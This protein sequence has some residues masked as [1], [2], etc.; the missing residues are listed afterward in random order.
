[1]WLY[2][3]IGEDQFIL[4]ISGVKER[5]LFKISAM[6]LVFNMLVSLIG[7]TY[8]YA[9]IFHSMSFPVF[10]AIFSTL[11]VYNIYK[12]CLISIITSSSKKTLGY[13]FSFLFRI[14]FIGFIGLL[15]A[16]GCLIAIYDMAIVSIDFKEASIIELVS[17]TLNKA[18]LIKV[19]EP[20]LIFLFVLPFLIKYAI[21][22][23]CKFSTETDI[24]S[25]NIVLNE[26]EALKKE[27][28]S[29]FQLKYNT[30]VHLKTDY[31]DP[32]FNTSKP[33]T[34]EEHYGNIEDLRQY[35]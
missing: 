21:G 22:K 24:I 3:L 15:V 11:I 20:L 26:Y 28:V 8:I 9:T 19:V 34:P 33:E 13:V 1:M 4:N 6:V 7:F 25:K 32:P 23:R 35:L 17:Q 2:R 27:Y 31:L 12:L 5:K 29:I 14:L 18:F 10:L 30:K 16:Q